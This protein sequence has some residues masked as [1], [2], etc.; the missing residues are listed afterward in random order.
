VNQQYLRRVGDILDFQRMPDI[1]W[2][3]EVMAYEEAAR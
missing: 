3:M 1:P 2:G